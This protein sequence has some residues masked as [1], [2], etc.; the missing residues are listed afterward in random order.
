MAANSTKPKGRVKG[1]NT[2]TRINPD[3]ARSRIIHVGCTVSELCQIFKTDSR[4]VERKLAR[5]GCKPADAVHQGTYL[6]PL[7]EAAD[8]L[9]DP[10]ADIEEVIRNMPASQ[11]PPMLQKE[12]WNGQNAK[13][14]YE[15]SVGDLWRTDAVVETMGEV[16]K[17][18]RMQILLTADQMERQT[19]LT[20]RQRSIV[21]NGM[22]ELLRNIR[23]RLIT[24]FAE[25]A[26]QQRVEARERASRSRQ[27]E[28]SGRANGADAGEPAVEDTD[29]GFEEDPTADL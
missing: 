22:D 3:N 4:A 12:F 29:Y 24:D 20:E 18:L 26:E 6:Y 13:L 16:F 7:K 21:K 14:K 28:N 9:A 8:C 11:L 10:I 5:G 2:P 27:D 19:E 1:S 17:T 23:E 15:E 25:R